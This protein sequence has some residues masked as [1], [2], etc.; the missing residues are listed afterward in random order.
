MINEAINSLL[1]ALQ[2]K[3]SGALDWLFAPIWDGWPLWWSWGVFGLVCLGCLFA[4]YFLPF[5]WTR[6]AL[7]GVVALAGAWLAG[8]ATMYRELKE[9]LAKRR[10]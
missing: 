7:G 2:A 9:R 10:R 5:K 4:G 1:A 3:A 6:A 8:R